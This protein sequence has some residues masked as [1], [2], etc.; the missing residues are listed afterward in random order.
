MQQSFVRGWSCRVVLTLLV[1]SATASA[2]SAAGHTGPASVVGAG[3]GTNACVTRYE[4]CNSGAFEYR[5]DRTNRCVA[6]ALRCFGASA[7]DVDYLFT[8]KTATR[9]WYRDSRPAG[10]DRRDVCYETADRC[11]RLCHETL[12]GNATSQSGGA[13]AIVMNC[14]RVCIAQ[15]DRCSAAVE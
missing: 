11:S 3:S 15:A 6:D 12:D 1:L 7:G 9:N 4:H 13:F 2:A 5:E 8:P 14:N 10:R